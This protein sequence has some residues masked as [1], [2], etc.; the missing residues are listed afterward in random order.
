MFARLY[1]NFLFEMAIYFKAPTT[2]LQHIKYNRYLSS[3]KYKPNPALR[4]MHTWIP[5]TIT[6]AFKRFI[7]S[8]NVPGRHVFFALNSLKSNFWDCVSQRSHRYYLCTSEISSGSSSSRPLAPEQ[9]AMSY[10][11]LKYSNPRVT[12][13]KSIFLDFLLT[14]LVP[15][16]SWFLRQ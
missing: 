8:S 9:A 6:H 16:H 12:L 1:A 7:E 5:V 14:I 11:I 10:L 13:S 4:A 15:F 3:I 2:D